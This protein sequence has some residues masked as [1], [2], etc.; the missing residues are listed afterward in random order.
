MKNDIGEFDA[1]LKE[2]PDIT[3]SL[4]EEY[5]RTLL[6]YGAMRGDTQIVSLL[7]KRDHDL[8]VVDVIGE[9]ALRWIVVHDDDDTLKLLK[10]LDATQ[11][12]SDVINKPT[13]KYND[14]PLHVAAKWNHHKSI[15][16]LLEHGSD[17]LLKNNH[18]ERPD[19]HGFRCDDKTKKIIRYFAR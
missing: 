8:S 14:T 7:S 6:M 13:H 9:N 11:L 2:Q 16:W 1:L 5:G 3:N 17:P 12:S 18:G 15:V 4:R 10:S 19:E